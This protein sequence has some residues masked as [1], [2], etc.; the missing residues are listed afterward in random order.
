MGMSEAVGGTL[1]FVF[2]ILGNILKFVGHY[3]LWFIKEITLAITPPKKNKE[4]AK[5]VRIMKKH[6]N[7]DIL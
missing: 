2:K 7:Q 1:G 6:K 3:L 4:Y 5:M